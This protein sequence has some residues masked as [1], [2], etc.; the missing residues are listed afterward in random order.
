MKLSMVTMLSFLMILSGL[1]GLEPSRAS[2]ISRQVRV[3]NTVEFL[4]AIAP[5]TRIFLDIED[6]QPIT[7]TD[8]Y[9]DTKNPYYRFEATYDGKQL[10][11]ENLEGLSI[12]GPEGRTATILSHHPFAN[13]IWFNNCNDIDLQWLNCGHEVLGFCT[14]GVLAFEDCYNVKISNCDLWGCGTEGLYINNC[15]GVICT[16]TTIRDCTYGILSVHN[17]RDVQFENCRMRDNQELDLIKIEDSLQVGFNN[18]AIWNNVCRGNYGSKYLVRA[19]NSQ[20]RFTGC[21]IFDNGVEALTN[22][23][24]ACFEECVIFANQAIREDD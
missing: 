5:H 6:D 8:D 13:V 19:N 24:D 2:G 3:T 21:A 14:G 23:E 22:T 16:D 7:F 17:S 9:P 4:A 11:I 1:M 15:N 10:V 18:C 12:A 20:V